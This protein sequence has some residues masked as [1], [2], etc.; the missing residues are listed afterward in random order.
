[1]S[2]PDGDVGEVPPI[3]KEQATQIIDHLAA[4]GLFDLAIIEKDSP[5]P[6]GPAYLLEFRGTR[7]PRHVVNLRWGPA[8]DARLKALQKVLKG[9]AGRAWHKL[10]DSLNG[11][12]KLWDALQLSIRSQRQVYRAGDK[13]DLH[14]TFLNRSKTGLFLSEGWLAPEHHET[15]PDRHFELQAVAEP[16][17]ALFF[18][19]ER[20]TEGES[21]GIPKIRYLGPGE[22]YQG[23]I[24][25]SAGSFED[26]RTR[27]AH[28]L[29]R[30]A[31]KYRV[32][33][34]Y[35]VGENFGI[36]EPPKDFDETLLWMGMLVSNEVAV[37]F[38]K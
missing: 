9:D 19:S 5:P 14:F 24:S 6:I 32:A 37:R 38:D 4:T 1:V 34:Q 18:W 31:S 11:P 10:L 16:S 2:P 23:T 15:G 33:L 17:T 3:S 35:F 27:K 22:T 28:R 7:T 21:G 8:L 36:L 29:G 13:V 30:D 12:R 20:L 26:K 25:L